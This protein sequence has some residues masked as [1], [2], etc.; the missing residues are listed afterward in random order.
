VQATELEES[1]FALMQKQ[2]AYDKD[3]FLCHLGRLS[4]VERATYHRKLE[5]K[6]QAHQLSQ[7]AVDHWWERNVT[8]ID[9]GGP[10]PYM[11]FRSLAGELSKRYSVPA[12]RV[13]APAASGL[14][15]CSGW[16]PE[17]DRS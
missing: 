9:S 16:Q 12:D 1:V 13:V 3:A 11:A 8:L 10:D 6:M 17:R 2:V 7:Q 15:E 4:N 14:G 5:W